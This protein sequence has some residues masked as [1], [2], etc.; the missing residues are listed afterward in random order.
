MSNG[1]VQVLSLEGVAMELTHTHLRYLAAVRELSGTCTAVSS[2]QVAALLGVSRPSVA[3]MLGVLAQR[4][5]IAK[6]H[7]GKVVLTPAGEAA[8][9]C[10][11]ARVECLLGRL[12]ELGLSLSREEALCAAGALA[13]VL[14]A[15]CFPK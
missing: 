11:Q 2:A 1:A 10:Y 3:R 6:E 14:P 8:A 7:Y 12:P 15:R 5:L 13:A 4:E 9:R